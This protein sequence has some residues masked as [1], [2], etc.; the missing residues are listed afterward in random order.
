MASEKKMLFLSLLVTR[1]GARVTTCFS[2][3]GQRSP[4]H[5][6]YFHTRDSKTLK[7]DSSTPRPENPSVHSSSSV[8][9]QDYVV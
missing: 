3:V 6:V 9:N 5:R 1:A 8:D 2:A 4:G 7:A